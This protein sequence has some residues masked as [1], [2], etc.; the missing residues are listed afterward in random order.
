MKIKIKNEIDRNDGRD[1]RQKQTKQRPNIKIYAMNK[2]VVCDCLC[3][4][5]P[6]VR[7]L[8]R[9]LSLSAC[10]YLWVALVMR[11][12]KTWIYR[13]I[14]GHWPENTGYGFQYYLFFFIEIIF[15][16]CR[17]RANENIY[18]RFSC[19]FHSDLFFF[20]FATLS[21]FDSLLLLGHPDPPP[22]TY[23]LRHSN[24][25]IF[26]VFFY[27]GRRNISWAIPIHWYIA[28]YQL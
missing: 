3:L 21:F 16:P 4:C 26:I 27:F 11:A 23:T 6:C 12:F 1:V 14:V 28:F 25:S 7:L 5:L 15:S 18:L 8:A 13:S 17:Q 22:Y 19:I 9:S 24:L 10:V 2:C 20:P